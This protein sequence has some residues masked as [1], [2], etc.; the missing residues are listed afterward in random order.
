MLPPLLLTSHC[1]VG[2]GLAVAAAVK[3]TLLPAATVWPLGSVVIDG[4]KS[5]VSVA[6]VVVA[7]P[8]PW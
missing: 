7:L 4:P 1:T 3:V 8:R 5:T 6:A 2:V